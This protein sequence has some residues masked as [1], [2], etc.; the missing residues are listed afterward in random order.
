MA[1]LMMSQNRSRGMLLLSLALRVIMLNEWCRLIVH[2]VKRKRC[3]CTCHLDHLNPS[4][5]LWLKLGSLEGCHHDTSSFQRLIW[6]MNLNY[7]LIQ[8]SC[9]SYQYHLFYHSCKKAITKDDTDK[10]KDF[11]ATFIR[12]KAMKKKKDKISKM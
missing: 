3:G 8:L 2:P 1:F 7:F 9:H 10:I 5:I 4:R 11:I 12:K 6:M